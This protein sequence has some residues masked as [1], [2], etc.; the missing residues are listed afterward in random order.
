MT[1]SV[2]FGLTLLVELPLAA[3]L[4]PRGMHRRVTCDAILINL[5]SHPLAWHTVQRGLAPWWS[6]ELAVFALEATLYGILTQLSARR[7]VSLAL[8]ANCVTATLS[9]VV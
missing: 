6:V 8:L 2:A 7:A 1:W 9:W 3:L 5:L 4:A